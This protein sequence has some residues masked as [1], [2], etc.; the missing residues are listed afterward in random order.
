MGFLSITCGTRINCFIRNFKSLFVTNLLFCVATTNTVPPI[1]NWKHVLCWVLF[2]LRSLRFKTCEWVN[3]SSGGWAQGSSKVT[4]AI[5]K[6]LKF[7]IKFEPQISSRQIIH[8]VRSVKWSRG[9]W[10]WFFVQTEVLCLLRSGCV[11]TPS[12]TP[13]P[14]FVK[15]GTMVLPP[16]NWDLNILI[17]ILM[18]CNGLFSS[19]S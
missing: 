8:F 10:D 7:E 16:N 3:A 13:P 5:R 1:F 12:P 11:L 2:Q 9:E 4:L 18:H 15:Q 6:T 17:S 14:P 19:A